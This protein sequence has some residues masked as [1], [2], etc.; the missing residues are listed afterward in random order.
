MRRS[1]PSNPKEYP[2]IRQSRTAAQ[3]PLRI[4]LSC[5]TA[6]TGVAIGLAASTTRADWSRGRQTWRNAACSTCQRRPTQNRWTSTVR[7]GHW[8]P[9][10]ILGSWSSSGQTVGGVECSRIESCDMSLR[11][12]SRNKGALCRRA[13]GRLGKILFV[14]C[15]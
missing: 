3:C 4:P 5:L 9:A 14:Y 12:C 1:S 11:R 13:V 10:C 8:T 6:G 15:Y 7:G 2:T